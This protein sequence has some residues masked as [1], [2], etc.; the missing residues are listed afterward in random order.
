[1][2]PYI[3]IIIIIIIIIVG[4]SSFLLLGRAFLLAEC[5]R[6]RC[7]LTHYTTDLFENPTTCGRSGNKTTK[8]TKQPHTAPTPEA[9]LSN[10]S[11]ASRE[12][13]ARTR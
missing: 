10:V 7:L 5:P 8:G 13:R 9:Q 12:K 11:P 2:K 1:M 6:S 4:L 3:I